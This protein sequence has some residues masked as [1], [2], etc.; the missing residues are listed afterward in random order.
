MLFSGAQLA[1]CAYT[2]PLHALTAVSRPALLLPDALC[3]T[4]PSKQAD[5]PWLVISWAPS[6]HAR[7]GTLNISVEPGSAVAARRQAATSSKEIV[8]DAIIGIVRLLG[9]EYAREA[10]EWAVILV[11]GGCLGLPAPQFELS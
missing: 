9:G 4:G 6:S 10:P 1:D 7:D 8:I 11:S 2:G 5:Q 3:V